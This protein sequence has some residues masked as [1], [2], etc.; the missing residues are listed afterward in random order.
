MVAHQ[1]YKV[2]YEGSSWPGL[3]PGQCIIKM[4][5]SFGD[6]SYFSLRQMN[7]KFI[8]GQMQKTEYKKFFVLKCTDELSNGLSVF[9]IS[10]AH[11][12]MHNK[13][14]NPQFPDN[15]EIWRQKI[16][17]GKDISLSERTKFF[18]HAFKRKSIV[19][20]NSFYILLDASIMT[21]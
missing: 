9:W 8:F 5:F 19:K 18:W 1:N 6:S 13:T 7:L 15:Q 21:E 10:I 3:M 4:Q 20:V 2:L 12:L 14:Q 17:F 16:W 11:V